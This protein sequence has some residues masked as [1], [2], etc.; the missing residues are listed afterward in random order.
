MS[1]DF[2]ARRTGYYRVKVEFQ[3]KQCA[4]KAGDGIRAAADL[5][6]IQSA[7]HP[8]CEAFEVRLRGHRAGTKLPK[9]SWLISETA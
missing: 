3:L 1:A 8:T 4:G 2:T 6:A 7:R 9:T 5:K